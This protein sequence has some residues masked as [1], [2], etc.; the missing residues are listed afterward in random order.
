MKTINEF[1]NE[2]LTGNVKGY[3]WSYANWDDYLNEDVTWEE[4]CGCDLGDLK[5]ADQEKVKDILDEIKKNMISCGHVFLGN[6]GE[7]YY[8]DMDEAWDYFY[9]KSGCKKKNFCINMF[10]DGDN[11]DYYYVEFKKNVDPK[12]VDDFKALFN[13]DV[14][15]NENF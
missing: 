8:D 11:G 5:P 4:F 14:L 13:D 7:G 3:L 10:Q 1:I 15:F 9:A 6:W 12:L 2:A